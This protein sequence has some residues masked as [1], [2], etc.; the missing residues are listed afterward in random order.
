MAIEKRYISTVEYSTDF[1]TASLE[2]GYNSDKL[3]K[4]NK[5]TTESLLDTVV[6]LGSFCEQRNFVEIYS[7]PDSCGWGRFKATDSI[8]APGIGFYTG[9][10]HGRIIAGKN[11]PLIVV[12][13]RGELV[14]I[15]D[16]YH[17]AYETMVFHAVSDH[18]C[19]FGDETEKYD[20]D[21]MRRLRQDVSKTLNHNAK[22]VGDSED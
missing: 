19:L 14:D 11:D 13:F 1:A 3:Q 12:S 21:H 5:V 16:G 9:F 2:F 4:F 8:D 15:P 18:D 20:R 7:E 6:R 17:S 22:I 10:F